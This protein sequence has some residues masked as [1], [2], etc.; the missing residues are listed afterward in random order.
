M[1]RIFALYRKSKLCEWVLVQCFSSSVLTYVYMM[2]TLDED[3]MIS[4]CGNQPLPR[5]FCL[6]GFAGT[7]S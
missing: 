1:E 7:S 6:L 5:H 2:F 3:M 4:V